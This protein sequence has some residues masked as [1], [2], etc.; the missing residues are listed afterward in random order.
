MLENPSATDK[1]KDKEIFVK[2]QTNKQRKDK[3]KMA[4][5]AWLLFQLI[6]LNFSIYSIMQ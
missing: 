6:I 3:K 4:M 1:D 5:F 2:K